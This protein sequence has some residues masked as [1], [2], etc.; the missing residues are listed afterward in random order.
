M[1]EKYLVK[2]TFDDVKKE[3]TNRQKTFG[4]KENPDRYT[5]KK[6]A[7]IRYTEMI[8]LINHWPK[9]KKCNQYLDLEF[10]FTDTA[11]IPITILY[12]IVNN[13]TTN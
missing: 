9:C 7:G 4:T 2:I 3:V 13:Y 8:Y 5:D 11:E 12:T 6:F 10:E 1:E